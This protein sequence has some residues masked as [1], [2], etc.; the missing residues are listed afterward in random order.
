MIK[1]YVATFFVYLSS[2]SLFLFRFVTL[3]EY[4]VHCTVER[5]LVVLR[6]YDLWA[7][8]NYLKCLSK[9]LQKIFLTLTESYVHCMVERL[10]VVLWKYE[11]KQETTFVTRTE[12]YLHC[13][14]ERWSFEIIICLSFF[15]NWSKYSKC[16]SRIRKRFSWIWLSTMCTAQWNS[17]WLSFDFLIS[18][19]ILI[20]FNVFLRNWRRFS[21]LWQNMCS[22]HIFGPS[23]LISVVQ[24][25]RKKINY[26]KC[27]SRIR[28]R[29]SWLGLNTMWTAHSEKVIGGP[30]ILTSFFQMSGLTSMILSVLPIIVCFSRITWK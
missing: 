20:F 10:L 27:F 30:L 12:Y 26:L 15:L 16:L 28:G 9:E 22:A 23:I 4:Y 2:F 7:N 25:S 3:T 8:F 24:I 11:I 18:G 5:L 29:F 21:W 14:V 13:T 19:L 1:I 6:F 17:C